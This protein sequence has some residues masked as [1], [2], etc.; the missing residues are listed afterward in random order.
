MN[1]TL[2]GRFKCSQKR[3]AIC[4]LG[5]NRWSVYLQG[6]DSIL[7]TLDLPPTQDSS[8]HKDYE[9]F[10]IGRILINFYCYWEG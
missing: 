9:T 10:L 3:N 1:T 5:S 4:L 6:N 7:D 2:P 8:H